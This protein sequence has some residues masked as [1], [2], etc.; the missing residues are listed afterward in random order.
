MACITFERH[1]TKELLG[2]RAA[3]KGN[4]KTLG[5][6]LDISSAFQSVLFQGIRGKDLAKQDS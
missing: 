4:K 6:C 2:I 5:N 1:T 3:F